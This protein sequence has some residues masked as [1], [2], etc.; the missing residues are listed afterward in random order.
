MEKKVLGII[1][2]LLG[3]VGLIAAAVYFMNGDAGTRNIKAIITFAILGTVFFAAGI[4]L[5]Q[6]TK[7]NMG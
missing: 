2:T 4:G 1:L 3:I 6:R 5:V 7:D